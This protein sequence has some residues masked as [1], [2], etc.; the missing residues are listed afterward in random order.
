MVYIIMSAYI[1][2]YMV[3]M[4]YVM[5]ND[6][7]SNYKTVKEYMKSKYY[8]FTTF[9]TSTVMGVLVVM[10]LNSEDWRYPLTAFMAIC[11]NNF[12]IGRIKKPHDK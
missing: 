11:I 5:G 8:L 10:Y 2:S 12:L 7:P 1:V 4:W 6:K 9:L 3:T